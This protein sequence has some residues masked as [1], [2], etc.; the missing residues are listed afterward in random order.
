MP[1][2]EGKSA[3]DVAA[4][5]QQ[6]KGLSKEELACL[7][8]QFLDSYQEKE[9]Y[10]DEGGEFWP[11]DYWVKLGLDGEAIKTKSLAKD[12]K[13]HPVFGTTYLGAPCDVCV[14][15]RCRVACS[16]GTKRCWSKS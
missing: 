3:E 15:K 12:V 6:A 5:F 1:S 13:N 4:F 7:S 9:Q 16:H 14:L 11:I 2:F 10:W 8:T